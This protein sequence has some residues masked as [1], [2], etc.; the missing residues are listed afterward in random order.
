MSSRD[1]G[2]HYSDLKRKHDHSLR[3]EKERSNRHS[4]YKRSSRYNRERSK[5]KS[6]S[7]SHNRHRSRSRSLSRQKYDKD[8]N[9]NKD[10]KNKP[11]GLPMQEE[12]DK[13]FKRNRMKS[14]AAL[15][16]MLEKEEKN[17][18]NEPKPL[19]DVDFLSN[20]NN[21]SQVDEKGINEKNKSKEELNNNA[22]AI[23]KPDG[24]GKEG[25]VGETTDV[26]I[27]EKNANSNS[28]EEEKEEADPLDEYMKRIEKDA[29]LQDYQVVQLL[30]T[31]NLQKEYDNLDINNKDFNTLQ[32]ENELLHQNGIDYSKIVT[33]DDMI[34][35]NKEQM[36]NNH[37]V[38]MS[39]TDN[40]SNEENDIKIEDF[41]Q[42]C[43]KVSEDK[44]EMIIYQ[45]DPIEFLK[46]EKTVNTEEQWKKLK[47]NDDKGKELKLVNHNEIV[48]ETFRKQL[49]I[50]PK[51]IIDLTQEEVD[52]MLKDNGNIKLRGKNIPKPIF[53]WYHC[54]LISSIVQV[55]EAKEMEKPFPI[56]MQSIPCIMS[57]RDVIG[58]AETGSGKTL[59]YVL[60]MLRHVLDQRL[61]KDGDGPIA[62]IMVP[63][64]ELAVQIYQ[65]IKCFSKFLKIDCSCVYGGSAIGQQISELRRGVEIVV[66]TPGRFI[67]IL[68]LSNGKITNLRRV[69][70]YFIYCI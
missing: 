27:E 24:N 3:Y 19:L 45:E 2:N 14:K 1:K 54:G 30:S 59:A 28:N 56:Q 60:P 5:S 12:K 49:Y 69:L 13:N 20:D 4:S 11:N 67:E 26:L 66:A 65:E 7:R 44:R 52:Q 51:E 31:Q 68:C 57:G 37:D 34:I 21:P 61:C 10:R 6:K 23:T 64:R 18:I 53:N 47:Q 70:Y 58:I 9:I 38:I 16:V 32:E 50:E 41:I 42:A 25:V 46:N 39:N 55:L 48:Y 17:K 22:M 43:E 29:T 36:N 15:L 8:Y 63:T 33:I 35:S 62:L 40:N